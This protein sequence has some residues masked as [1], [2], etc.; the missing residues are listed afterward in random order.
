MKATFVL[1]LSLA[2]AY[3]ATHVNISIAQQP[4]TNPADVTYIDG[5]KAP[6]EL[7]AGPTGKSAD[8]KYP[9]DS[10]DGRSAQLRV[11]NNNANFN[12]NSDGMNMGFNNDGRSARIET[13]EN[14]NQMQDGGNKMQFHNAHAPMKSGHVHHGFGYD[15]MSQR[16]RQF[17]PQNAQEKQN[18]AFERY[19]QSYHSGPTV[20][21]VCQFMYVH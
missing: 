15:R 13:V 7:K 12:S 14:K 5:G 4:V 2:T 9:I 21:T 3:G 8:L 10:N 1:L 16:Q 11:A 20:E 6:A 19:I 18:Q 17:R